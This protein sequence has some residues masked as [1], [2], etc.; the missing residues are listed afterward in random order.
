MTARGEQ[1]G[2]G[3]GNP[4][5]S[6]KTGP[7]KRWTVPVVVAALLAAGVTVGIASYLRKGPASAS[8]P[9]LEGLDPLLSAK[10]FDEVERRLDA[11]LRVHPDSAQ[12]NML[13]AQ[14]AL[15]RDEQ[16]PR[17]AL[18]HLKRV[19]PSGRASEAVVRLNEGKAFSAMGAHGRAEGAWLEALRADPLVPEAGWALLGLYYVQG[20]REDAHRLGM[21]LHGIEP[22]PRDRVQLLLELVRQDAQPLGVDSVIRTF[23]PVVRAHPEDLHPAIALALASIRNSRSGEGLPILRRLAGRFADAPVA[24]DAL[25]TGLEEAYLADELA[26]ALGQLPSTMAGDPRFERHRGVVAQNRR[27]WSSAADAFLRAWQAD[28]S[29]PHVLYRLSRMLR[30]SGRGEEADRF[31]AKVRAMESARAEALPL[32]EEA[33][34]DKTLGAGPHAAL[35]QR[36]ADLRERM[37]RRDEALAWH[38]LVL[39]AQPDDPTSRAALGRLSDAGPPP[40]LRE[41][42]DAPR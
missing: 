10:R 3:V 11:Y 15:A 26:E 21:A 14:V 29:D 25:L 34:A 42:L 22:D 39:E 19:R 18:E 5:S 28:P 40:S 23:E 32:Y 38:R 6:E 35:Y 31:D 9:T 24:W 7:R 12:A 2:I 1:P 17:L 37:G 16:K 33:N 20:R 4:S 41:V 36:L 27:D 8:A 30:S 13:M